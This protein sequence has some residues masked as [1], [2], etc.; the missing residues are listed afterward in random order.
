[1]ARLMLIE[2]KKV[3]PILFAKSGP[4]CVAEGFCPEGKMSCGKM[5]EMQAL[6]ASLGQ[7]ATNG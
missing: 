6:Y 2:V 3:A 7:E 4:A 1:M 5:K